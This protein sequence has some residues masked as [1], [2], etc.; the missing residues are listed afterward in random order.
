M[1][2][3]SQEHS[4]GTQKRSEMGLGR[5]LGSPGD[6]EKRP[7]KLEQVKNRFFLLLVSGLLHS[8][9]GS[10]SFAHFSLLFVN[11][12]WEPCWLPGEEFGNPG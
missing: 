8:F 10:K 2:L 5:Q 6:E 7:L 9:R 3:K 4:S 11:I 12:R 1:F